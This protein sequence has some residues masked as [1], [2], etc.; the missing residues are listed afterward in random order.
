MIKYKC[1]KNNDIPNQIILS[2]TFEAHDFVKV[3]I[4]NILY[5]MV[6][7][8]PNTYGHKIIFDEETNKWLN[9]STMI[10]AMDSFNKQN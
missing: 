1:N 4:S 2:K 10:M 5:E 8:L 6:F 9:Y 3:I 7:K